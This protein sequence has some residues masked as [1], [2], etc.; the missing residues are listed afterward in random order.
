MA[1]VIK[2]DKKSFWVDASGH[3]VPVEYI[4]KTIK[5]RDKIVHSVIAKAQRLNKR[6]EQE[7]LAVVKSIQDYLASV[8]GKYGESWKGNTTLYNFDK[9]LKI[10][11]NIS[12]HIEF[13]ERLQIAKSK[14]D[15]CIERWSEGSRKEIATLI[16][17]AFKVDKKGCINTKLILG[18]RQHKFDDDEW[19][20]AM[21][22]ISDAI[23]VVNSKAYYKF[24][25]KN[26]KDTWEV[27][28]LNFSNI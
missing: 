7:K 26:D 16:G 14:I 18:L 13:D 4:D 6:L 5:Q 23:C 11:V 19:K 21:D 12:E 17:S 3:E 9:T 24:F 25:I 1:N 28:Q 10:E 2:K 20:E 15:H 22:I 8:A 27:V